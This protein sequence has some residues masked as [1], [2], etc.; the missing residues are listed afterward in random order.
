MTAHA[1]ALFETAIGWCGIAWNGCGIAGVQLPEADEHYTRKRM[2]QRF[3][4][5]GEAIPPPEI[6]RVL[7]SIVALLDG[8]PSNLSD[9]ELDMVQPGTALAEFYQLSIAALAERMTSAGVMTADEAARLTA[10]PGEPDF[11]GCGF[12]HIG[13]WGRRAEPAT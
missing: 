3:P 7:D 10:R 9:A 11:L 8:E 13:V 6:R 5:A 1:F 2:L 12:A 4:A